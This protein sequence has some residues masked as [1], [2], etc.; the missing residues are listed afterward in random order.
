MGW[1]NVNAVIEGKLYLGNILAATST[2]SLTER[3]ITHIVSVCCD[4]IPAEVPES[5]IAH[6][7]ISVEDVDYADI[8]IEMPRACRFIDQ[9]IRGGGTVLVHC[10]QGLTRGATIVAA[11]LMCTKRISASQA[12]DEV[13]KA[14]EQAWFNAGFQEQLVLFELCRYAPSPSCGIYAS[15]RSN[16]AKHLR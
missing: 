13:R 12:M 14:R 11:Y 10:G 3:R 5:G 15:W 2:R 9:A 1:K 8:L 16:V 7:R 4:P 6:M